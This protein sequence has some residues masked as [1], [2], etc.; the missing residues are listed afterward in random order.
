MS[1]YSRG[2]AEPQVFTSERVVSLAESES[3]TS[4]FLSQS[5]LS[6]SN[7]KASYS[8]KY[9]TD[10]INMQLS[11]FL[12]AVFSPL[13][14]IKKLHMRKVKELTTTTKEK[15]SYTT[16]LLRKAVALSEVEC[17]QS[18]VS[19]QS[20]VSLCEVGESAIGPVSLQ[21]SVPLFERVRWP[22]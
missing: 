22:S 10:Y 1:V 2:R 11:F 21:S 18:G 13:P 19:S 17:W 8:N 7:Q 12:E 9:D 3:W 4:F 15:A 5:S 14:P 16:F 20:A 6:F